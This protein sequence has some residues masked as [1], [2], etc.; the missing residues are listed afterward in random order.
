MHGFTRLGQ[1]WLAEARVAL[2]GASA[3]A[4]H[5]ALGGPAPQPNLPAGAPAEMWPIVLPILFLSNVFVGGPIAEELGWRGFALPRLQARIGALA[6]G[7]V[8]GAAW[9]LWHLPFFLFGEGASVVGDTPFVWYVL[10]VTAWP[11][12]MTWV[13]NNAR[14]SV[15]L[16]VLFHAGINTTMGRL[17]LAG[18]SG[19]SRLVVLNV[20]LTWLVVA[21]VS[22][23]FGPARLVHKEIPPLRALEH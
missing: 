12:L 11:A 13:Y 21:A 1:M 14:E 2:I 22:I 18:A 10:L 3:L 7:L 16:M 4:L 8:L 20:A 17:G 5:V 6:A 23:R 9:G 15:L 19:G